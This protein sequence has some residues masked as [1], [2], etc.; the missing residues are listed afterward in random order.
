MRPLFRPQPFVLIAFLSLVL[1]T[2]TASLPSP[3]AAAPAAVPASQD[4]A[5]VEDALFA[6]LQWRNIGPANMAGRMTDIEAVGDDFSTVFVAAASGGVWKSTN[7][8]TTWTPIFEDYGI[9]RF[10][11]HMVILADTGFHRAQGDPPNLKLCKRG[12]WNDRMKVE[13][14]LSMLTVVCHLKKVRHR[15][16]RV[17]VASGSRPQDCSGP[18]APRSPSRRRRIVYSSG[19]RNWVADPGKPSRNPPN[20]RTRPWSRP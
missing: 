5:T 7:A 3:A 12:E 2:S 14:V 13:T 4:A 18:R 17:R 20:S 19:S 16:W 10:E 1:T 9:E 8:G 15:V 6:D 11:A